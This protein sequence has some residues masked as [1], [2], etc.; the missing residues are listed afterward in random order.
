MRKLIPGIV[1]GA[2]VLS[3]LWVAAEARAGEPT[4][5]IRGVVNEVIGILTDPAFQNPARKPELR[6]RIKAA[7]DRRFDYAE[8]AKRS[9]GPTWRRLSGA[10]QREFTRLFAQLL[11]A[12]YSDKLEHYSGEIVKFLGETQDGEFAEVRTVLVRRNDRIPMNYRLIHRSGWKV[13][14]VVIEGVSLVNNYRSQF[15]RIIRQQSYSGLVQR[16]RTKVRELQ[17][18]RAH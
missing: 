14:D 9:L 2:L 12:S 7:V 16:L 17:Q 10:Q 15:R 18:R 5:T 13:Y 4:E 3:L 11:E 8:M 1:T 6:R